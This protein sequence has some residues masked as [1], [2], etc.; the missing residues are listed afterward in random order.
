[1]KDN[2]CTR[3]DSVFIE[4]GPLY[5]LSFEPV[6]NET[7]QLERKGLEDRGW[8]DA[9]CEEIVQLSAHLQDPCRGVFLDDLFGDLANQCFPVC[10]RDWCAVCYFLTV[11]QGINN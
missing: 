5:D 1:M 6:V 7:Q 4:R 8:W 10:R 9:M 3:L 2:L 11:V